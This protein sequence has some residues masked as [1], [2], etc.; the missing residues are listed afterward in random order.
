MATSLNFCLEG[1][2]ALI[3]IHKIT[4]QVHT[5]IL[6]NMSSMRSWMRWNKNIFY[7]FMFSAPHSSYSSEDVFDF[8]LAWHNCVFCP[9]TSFPSQPWSCYFI[10]STNCSLLLR[11]EEEFDTSREIQKSLGV[12]GWAPVAKCNLCSSGSQRRRSPSCQGSK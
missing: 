3:S 10:P 9:D 8:L 1:S 6:R 12:C 7:C 4:F 2:S 11:R 5:Q